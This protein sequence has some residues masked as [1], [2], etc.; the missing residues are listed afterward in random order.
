VAETILS[1]KAPSDELVERVLETFL[2]EKRLSNS[3]PPDVP[4]IELDERD[5]MAEE[6]LELLSLDEVHG[7]NALVSGYSIDFDPGLT[8]LFGQNASGKTG[9]ARIIKR[10][11][12]VRTTE[13]ILPNAYVTEAQPSPSA[14]I[15]YRLGQSEHE[16]LWENE[17]GVAPFTR[18]S[19]FDSF[20]TNIHTDTE[21]GYV[22]TPAELALFS[23]VADGIRKLNLRIAAE[24]S[25]LRPSTNP[26]AS[27]FA[28]G[29]AVYQVV[30][31]LGPT[32]DV[33]EL[34][35]LSA[36]EDGG[37]QRRDQLEQEVGA[38][39]GGAVEAILVAAQQRL[40]SFERLQALLRA[41]A[42][43][44]AP[45]YGVALDAYTQA[46]ANRRRVREE[47]F[48][49]D[50]LPGPP[51]NRWQ[52]FVAAAEEYRQHLN[53]HDYP[54]EGDRCLYCR[55]LL[56]PEALDLVRR[57]RAFLDE[58][59]VRQVT[60]AAG[61]VDRLALRLDPTQAATV[62]QDL[63]AISAVETCPSWVAGGISLLE[64]AT[65]AAE[66]TAVRRA[67]ASTDLAERAKGL[68]GALASDIAAVESQAKDLVEQKN[69]RA[70]A[71][72]SKQRELEELSSR[73]ELNKHLP[74]AKT[75]VAMPRRRPGWNSCRGRSRITNSGS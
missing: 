67:C 46:E 26:L 2:A 39:R 55:Q 13:E 20:S 66:D 11:A 5:E 41:V 64:V 9:Y 62:Q 35:R 61:R 24:V 16:T 65:K 71:F 30:E 1:R 56:A 74:A 60:D 44:S 50:G 51:D 49:A 52:G 27:L 12:A 36:L 47:L 42:S 45:A 17:A 23:H 19:V 29:T 33:S 6:A 40:A 25:A 14:R 43:F 10:L 69:N 53:L 57:Y 7:V 63:A 4:L 31:S 37:I 21:L 38:L 48:S 54:D 34:E 22:F 3:P 68:L 59:L 18:I 15:R 70:A 8:I 28:R 73:I 72:K 58:D 32:T 75:F